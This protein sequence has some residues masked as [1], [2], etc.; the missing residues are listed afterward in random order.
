MRYFQDWPKTEKPEFFRTPLKPENL[1]F[2]RIP[3][4]STSKI[5]GGYH[6]QNFNI[7][8]IKKYTGISK[9]HFWR[10]K[11]P[12]FD[13]LSLHISISDREND[14]KVIFWAWTFFL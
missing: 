6:I 2:L 8:K 5:K 14:L 12:I 7:S 4:K 3:W 9:S 10:F 1:I 11:F 13:P